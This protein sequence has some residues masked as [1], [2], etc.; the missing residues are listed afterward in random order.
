MRAVVVCKCGKMFKA[1]T[2]NI[3]K[4]K[5]K[6]CSKKCMYLYRKRPKGLKYNL[7]SINKSWIK[8]GQRISPNTEF[9][10]GQ[11][12]HNYKHKNIIDGL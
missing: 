7:I 4:G 10:K 2:C 1:H 6:Y 5:G 8:K 12:P 9:K 3:K 11:R